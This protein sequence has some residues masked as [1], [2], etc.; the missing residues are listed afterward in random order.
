MSNNSKK[1]INLLSSI[2]LYSI[3]AII[4]LIIIMFIA[5]FIDQKIAQS[6]GETRSPLFGAYVIISD[7]MVPT[8]NVRDAVVTMRVDHSKLK[9]NDIITF[10]SKDI[11]TQGTP[12]THR[13]VGI[14]YEDSETKSKVLGYRTKGDHNNTQDFALIRPEEVLGKVYLR[15]PLLGY[16][17]L[18]LTTPI[19][20]M[21]VIVLPCLIIIGNDVLKIGKTIKEK[22]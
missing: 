3:L 11:E 22:E 12:I 10:I 20:W 17:Q 21:L 16:L 9:V 1:V 19:G 14:V 4:G 13:I 6:K 7:S 18:F 15:I 2:L 5:Y 8:I